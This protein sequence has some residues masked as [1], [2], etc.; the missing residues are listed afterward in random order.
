MAKRGGQILVNVY[1][2]STIGIRILLIF[3]NSI[4]PTKV[5]VLFLAGSQTLKNTFGFVVALIETRCGLWPHITIEKRFFFYNKIESYRKTLLFI[6]KLFL[7][8]IDSCSG[9]LHY[10][11]K[12]CF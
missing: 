4:F 2:T 7:F 3:K 6:R 9:E 1:S 11:I 10:I 12:K 8:L 5:L